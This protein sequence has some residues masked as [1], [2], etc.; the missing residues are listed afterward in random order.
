MWSFGKSRLTTEA[1]GLV[2]AQIRINERPKGASG[3]I[4]L[5][6]TVRGAPKPVETRLELDIPVAKP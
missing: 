3:P 1:D 6:F 2:T 5:I 4:P